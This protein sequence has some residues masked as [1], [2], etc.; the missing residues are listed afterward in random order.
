MAPPVPAPAGGA[1]FGP[2]AVDDADLADLVAAHLGVRRATVLASSVAVFPYERPSITT[3]GRF[4]V[5]GR[6][7]VDSGDVLAFSFFVKVIHA[8]GRSP[9]RFAVPEHLRA[10][11]AL[12]VP[13]R[14]EADLYRAGLRELLPHGL[15]APRAVAV[16]DLDDESVAIWLEQVP[17]RP[18]VWDAHRRAHAAFLLG[19]FAA[20]RDVAPLV[21]A[22]HGARN[23][24]TYA[25]KWLSHTVLPVLTGNAM[26]AHPL[27]R[28]AFDTRLRRRL[29]AAADALPALL[30]ELDDAPH[31][32]AHGDAC[33]ANLLVAD[34]REDV[35]MVDF[36]FCGRAPLGTD[37]G[38]LLLGD[39]DS[40]K[41][42]PADLPGLEATCLQ[43]FVAG[44]HAEGGTAD[45][46]RVR[47]IHAAL[48][49]VF[50][51][52]PAIPFEHLDDEPTP[53]VRRLFR[54]R[55]ATA[56]FVLDLLDETHVARPG[57]ATA[58]G[59]G[60]TR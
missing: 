13:W 10:E 32:T 3:A 28:D 34:D 53:Q 52:L 6:A 57:G 1:V 19:R 48:M 25:D 50:S 42:F 12:L 17:A 45:P 26:W 8:Y 39:V 2:A 14:T 40:A 15:T 18:V 46:T 47:R 33:S 7:R 24:R 21:T 44:I 56:G 35:V 49:T 20:S 11:A 60:T 58:A 51:A 59:S 23:P 43:A 41:R 37:L 36:G 29:L 30:D 22:V 4:V 5:S 27:V 54:R 55:A 16:R 9:L 31:V 38:Q